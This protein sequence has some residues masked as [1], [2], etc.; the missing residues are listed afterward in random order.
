MV[1]E[2]EE[3]GKV[4]PI[5]KHFGDKRIE[6]E[7]F[8]LRPGEI[9][10]CLPMPDKSTIILKCDRVIP[11]DKDHDLEFE[12]ARLRTKVYERKLA[13][14]I[15]KAFQDMRKQADP[16]IFLPREEIT[17]QFAYRVNL[18]L[19]KATKARAQE[20]HQPAVPDGVDLNRKD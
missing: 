4:P 3:G 15:P 1:A 19:S 18:E 12:R 10:K 17:K 6:E 14:A 2:E 9:S 8:S 20:T 13:E 16:K 11:E 5:H 7:A